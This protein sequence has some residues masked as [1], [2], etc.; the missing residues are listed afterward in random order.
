MY[1]SYLLILKFI[2]FHC[3]NTKHI[4]LQLAFYMKFVSESFDLA[5]L[6]KHKHE[7][8]LSILMAVR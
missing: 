2:I 1:L 7:C 5:S 8:I 6:N 4:I 3:F